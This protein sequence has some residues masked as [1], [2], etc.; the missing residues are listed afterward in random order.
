MLPALSAGLYC[1]K[2]LI[3][4]ISISRREEVVGG[5]CV[6]PKHLGTWPLEER[7]RT[8]EKK[9]HGGKKHMD[10][11]SEAKHPGHQKAIRE[12]RHKKARS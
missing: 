2:N 3:L 10:V 12:K 7:A 11:N 9:Q 8:K 1:D 5:E 6:D 4:L